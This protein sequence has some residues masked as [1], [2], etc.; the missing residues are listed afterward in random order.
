MSEPAI[1]RGPE[2]LTPQQRSDLENCFE[3]IRR[4]KRDIRIRKAL[5]ELE[6]ART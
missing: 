5:K 6:I 3:V 4:I 1:R 2:D